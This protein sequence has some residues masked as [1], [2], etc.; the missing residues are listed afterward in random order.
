MKKKAFQIPIQ[1]ADYMRAMRKSWKGVH[2][3]TRILLTAGMGIDLKTLL[4]GI[5]DGK[6]AENNHNTTAPVIN[7]HSG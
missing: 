2:P 5:I 7:V 1:Q 6:I 3:V 4:S